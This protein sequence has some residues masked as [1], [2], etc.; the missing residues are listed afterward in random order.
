MS[1]SCNYPNSVSTE[2]LGHSASTVNPC[3]VWY[4]PEFRNQN[5]N[6]GKNKE[7]RAQNTEYRIGES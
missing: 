2:F 1:E 4:F 5:Q 3:G 6:A 7:A